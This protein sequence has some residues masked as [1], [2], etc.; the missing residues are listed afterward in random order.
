MLLAIEEASLSLP[1]F[2]PP[3]LEE[4]DLLPCRVAPSAWHFPSLLALRDLEACN[5]AKIARLQEI[6]LEMKEAREAVLLLYGKV[7]LSAL[8]VALG[9]CG[10][11]W[12]MTAAP[13]TE[14]EQPKEQQPVESD[15]K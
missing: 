4:E 6:L 12:K 7:A 2:R 9:G 13:Q 14:E 3:S 5:E 11:F 1:F 15:T 8:L 10:F